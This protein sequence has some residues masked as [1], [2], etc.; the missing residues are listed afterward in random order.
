MVIF[1]ASVLLMLLDPSLPVPMDESTGKPVTEANRRIRHLIYSLHKD[2][3]KIVIPTPALA[4]VLTRAERAGADYLTKLSH[5][6]A[7]RIE[8]FGIRAAVELARMNAGAIAQGDKRSGLSVSW[9]KV[10]FDRQIVAIA[11]A[12]SITTIYSD[13]SD[14]RKLA[15]AYDFTVI[16]TPELPLPPEDAQL[17]F[18]WEVRHEEEPDDE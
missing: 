17:T 6:A 1:D 15:T 10:N 9:A 5:S 2:R 7:F 11:R 8:S 4:E 14:F 12:T 18:A 16:G 3:T 13:D